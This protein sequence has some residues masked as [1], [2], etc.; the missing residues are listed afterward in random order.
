MCAIEAAGRGRRVTILEHNPQAGRKLRVSGGG[1]CNFTNL[2]VGAE[3]YVSANPHFCKSALN[4]FAP[5]DFI[6][7]LD[8]HNIAY[9]ERADGQLFCRDGAGLIVEQLSV[10]CIDAGVDIRTNCR[11]IQVEKEERF[12]VSTS[13][14]T[15]NADSLVIATGG[16]SYPKLGATGF[17]H[18]IARQFGVAC[19]PLCMALVP[20]TWEKKDR[21]SFSELSGASLSVLLSCNGRV[22]KGD[23]LFTHKGLSGPAILQASLYWSPGDM[24]EIDLLPDLDI[25]EIL[26]KE[27]HS[28]AE[29]KTILSHYLPKKVIHKW[30]EVHL[31]TRPVYQYNL[32]ELQNIASIL[33]AWQIRPAGTEGLDTAEVTSGGVDTNEISSKT[34]EAKKVAGLF[35]I[36]EVLDVTGQLG[37]YNLQWAWSSGHAAGQYV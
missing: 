8:S 28:R 3:H 25:S 4:R 32:R 33:K 9:Q 6:E 10:Q 7:L 11:V 21:E 36:G 34:M 14:G 26:V 17:G 15:F 13:L 35:F 31:L 12:I 23:M 2:Y 22:F 18:E 29:L 27:Q 20:F 1:K 37:G 19:T 5:G 24:L 16:L 30:C